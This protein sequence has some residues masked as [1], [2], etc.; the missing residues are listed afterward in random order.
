MLLLLSLLLLFRV[1]TPDR[2]VQCAFIPPAPESTFLSRSRDIHRD[3]VAPKRRFDDLCQLFIYADVRPV[4]SFI[5]AAI[6][7]GCKTRNGDLIAD[8]ESHL[9]RANTRGTARSVTL[10]S[11]IKTSFN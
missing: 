9:T 10:I 3:N 11:L 4:L 1:I 2:T 6:F 5:A 7:R 8:R